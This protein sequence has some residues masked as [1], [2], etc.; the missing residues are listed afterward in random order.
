MESAELRWFVP[1]SAAL[2]NGIAVFLQA[3]VSAPRDA[4]FEHEGGRLLRCARTIA[5]LG[6][7]DGALA[8][9]SVFLSR[10]MDVDPMLLS[11]VD[12]PLLAHVA[13][14]LAGAPEGS[15]AAGFREL[16]L[17]YERET[18]SD[19]PVSRGRALRGGYEACLALDLAVGVL[20]T[21]AARGLLPSEMPD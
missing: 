21:E 8:W 12:H 13:D 17:A 9:S 14:R 2:S 6:G 10:Q 7:L 4:Q 1:A 5:D 16:L 20:C 19:S 11:R 18:F 3:A 15:L